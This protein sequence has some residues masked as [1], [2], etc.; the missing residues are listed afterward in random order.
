MHKYCL[1]STRNKAFFS[2]PY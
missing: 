1:F 2:R